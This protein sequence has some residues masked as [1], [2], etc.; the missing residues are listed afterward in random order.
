MLEKPYRGCT[1]VY[2]EFSEGNGRGIVVFGILNKKG[3][4]RQKLEDAFLETTEIKTLKE[5]F[6]FEEDYLLESCPC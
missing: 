1:V 5:G 2:E 6:E 3:K 4:F